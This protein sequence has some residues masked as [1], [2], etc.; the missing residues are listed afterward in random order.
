VAQTRNTKPNL[1]NT[2]Q[3]SDFGF[4]R[5][6]DRA[7][8]KAMSLRNKVLVFALAALAVVG[9]LSFSLTNVKQASI[10]AAS[11]VWGS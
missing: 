11:A 8:V 5:A 1:I 10:L 4:L 7:G 2:L 9:G 3:E 6:I